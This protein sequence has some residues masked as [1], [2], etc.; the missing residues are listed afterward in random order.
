MTTRE[1]TKQIVRH[2]GKRYEAVF[3]ELDKLEQKRLRR[4]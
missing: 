4:R 3:V 2:G 1:K